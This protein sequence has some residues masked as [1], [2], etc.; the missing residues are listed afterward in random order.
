MSGYFGA[1]QWNFFLLFTVESRINV[2]R[3]T[4]LH[5]VFLRLYR[6]E[7]GVGVADI[8]GAALTGVSIGALSG[9]TLSKTALA[10]E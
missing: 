5:A 2:G 6:M 8:S 10:L 4:K 9:I 7:F 3:S 1:V